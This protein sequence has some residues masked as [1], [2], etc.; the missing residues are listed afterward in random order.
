VVDLFAWVLNI[1][2]SVGIVII[3]KQLMAPSGYGFGYATCLTAAHYVVTT[4]TTC[5]S[6]ASGSTKKTS[7]PFSD[8]MLFTWTANASIISLTASLLLN[9]VSFYQICKLLIIPFTC[10]VDYFWLGKVQSMQGVIAILVVI[11]GVALVTV[12]DLGTDIPPLGLVM[13][14][15][16]IA[17]SSMQ[18]IFVG[19]MQKKHG[20]S[21][22]ELLSNTAPAQAVTLLAIGPFMDRFISSS[23]VTEYEWHVPSIV[24][25]GI[26]CFFAVLVNISQF[27]C[28]GRFSAV[29]FQVLGHS[30]TISVLI[31]GFLC[32][33]EHM[34]GK[35]LAGMGLAI[36]GMVAYGMAPKAVEKKPIVKDLEGG[37]AEDVPAQK[38]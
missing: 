31:L 26:S 5:V 37:N 36:I 24:F 19:H 18:Q 2:S 25:L 8:L 32:F 29:S 30:K 13:A 34:G 15:F 12:N 22:N 14:A 7:L 3:N 1:F 11:F 4:M 35:K 27:M 20:L 38:S 10:L 9:P 23:W 6:R 17:T 21:S 33:G 28:I 16:Q